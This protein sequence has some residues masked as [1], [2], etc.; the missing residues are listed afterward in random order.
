MES[1]NLTGVCV[2]IVPCAA[3][4]SAACAFSVIAVAF[5]ETI[6]ASAVTSEALAASLSVA[7]VRGPSIIYS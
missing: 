1:A 2:E 5:S 7:P 4:R 3:T 6:A